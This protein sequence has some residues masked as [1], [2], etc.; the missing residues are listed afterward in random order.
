[1]SS[2]SGNNNRVPRELRVCTKCSWHCV[3]DEEHV[4]LDCPSADLANLR[5]KHHQLF[6]SPSRNSNRL[7]DFMSQANTKGLALYVHECLECCAYISGHNLA[8]L[9]WLWLQACLASAK[10]PS[11]GRYS[12]VT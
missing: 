12:F 11:F 6:R 5:V 7:R 3:Q 10:L 4:L 8:C 9:F 2:A 1:M